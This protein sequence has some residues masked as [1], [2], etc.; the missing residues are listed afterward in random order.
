MSSRTR[1]GIH[2]RHCEERSDEAILSVIL[3]K[4]GIQQSPWIPTTCP[5]TTNHQPPKAPSSPSPLKN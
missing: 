5:P 4:A 3:A 1:F 2:P